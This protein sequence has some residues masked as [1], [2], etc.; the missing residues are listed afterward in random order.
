MLPI[1]QAITN[2]AQ[3]QSQLGGGLLSGAQGQMGNA[4]QQAMGFLGQTA[5]PE[6]W[7]PTYM[8]YGG[9]ASSNPFAAGL[10]F[11]GGLAPGLT[12]YYGG[13]QYNL[14]NTQAKA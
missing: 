13:G 5:A 6:W 14:P 3:M 10:G 11:L 9:G 7:Q 4:F 2:I 12:S 1:S 8:T